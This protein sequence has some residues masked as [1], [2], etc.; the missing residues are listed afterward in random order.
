MIKVPNSPFVDWEI[1][2]RT[3]GEIFFTFPMHTLSIR[4]RN[5]THL[6]LPSHCNQKNALYA[7]G[8]LAAYIPCFEFVPRGLVVNSNNQ[9]SPA[10]YIERIETIL[11]ISGDVQMKSR[12]DWNIRM[13][14]NITKL[15]SCLAGN[16]LSSEVQ[17]DIIKG[18]HFQ[19]HCPQRGKPPVFFSH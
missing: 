9:D 17:Y 19:R 2:L 6:K 1:T 18:K 10:L 3:V 11:T 12:E 8:S 14:N 15:Y 13:K 7:V 4:A 16:G 5:G